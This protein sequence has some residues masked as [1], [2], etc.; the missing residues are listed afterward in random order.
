MLTKTDTDYY[1]KL[2]SIPTGIEYLVE[3]IDLHK[4][5]QEL[6]K[7]LDGDISDYLADYWGSS[8][9]DQISQLIDYLTHTTT[10]YGLILMHDSE[11]DPDISLIPLIKANFEKFA[12]SDWL[13]S[14]LLEN[15]FNENIKNMPN[16]DNDDTFNL[17]ES[18]AL[19]DVSS[20][21]DIDMVQ[22]GK[23]N[24]LILM[25]NIE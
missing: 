21:P 9:D 13:D 17:F 22:Q 18:F 11:M 6:A 23:K 20:L 25:S 7:E 12:N 10:Q 4:Y 1:K 24:P 5:G 16:G 3:V 19:E 8:D 15:W 14:K 2:T